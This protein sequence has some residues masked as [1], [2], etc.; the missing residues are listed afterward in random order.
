MKADD[1]TRRIMGPP[2]GTFCDISL[3]LVIFLKFICASI[4]G[5]KGHV[6]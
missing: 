1:V 5:Q 6:D 4:I 3:V 2:N